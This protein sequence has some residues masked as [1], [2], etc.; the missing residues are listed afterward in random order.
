[1][2]IDDPEARLSTD[3]TSCVSSSGETQGVAVLV[4]H[5]CVDILTPHT[6]AVQY[7]VLLDI[8]DHE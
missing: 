5:P 7:L 2:F 6:A 4:F 8:R 1:V 3:T